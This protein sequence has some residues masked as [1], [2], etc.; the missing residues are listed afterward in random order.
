[1]AERLHF[2]PEHEQQHKA[3]Q[4]NTKQRI[5]IF[6]EHEQERRADHH[7]SHAHEHQH[8]AEHQLKHGQSD[9]LLD[10]LSS[11]NTNTNTNTDTHQKET[12]RHRQ[13]QTQ[14]QNDVQTPLGTYRSGAQQTFAPVVRRTHTYQNI[15]CSWFLRFQCARSKFLAVTHR[16]PNIL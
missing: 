7:H 14:T 5:I 6:H 12:R 11:N 2:H 16:C 3:K 10:V 13:T 15:L 8:W 4:Q 1:M 9:H